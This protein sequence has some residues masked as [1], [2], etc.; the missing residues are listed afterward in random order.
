MD[1]VEF[2]RKFYL[3]KSPLDFKNLQCDISSPY[4]CET[5][6][7]FKQLF[8]I[9]NSDSLEYNENIK[10]N[11]KSK[12]ICDMT[13]NVGIFSIQWGYRCKRDKIDCIEIDADIYNKLCYNIKYC[14]LDNVN[15]INANSYTYL[16]NKI[17]NKKLLHQGILRENESQEFLKVS[18]IQGCEE[19][20]KYDFIY[21]DPCFGGRNY[22]EQIKLDLYFQIPN[23]N[24]DNT[25]KNINIIDVIDELLK[26]KIT[27]KIFLKI[28]TNFNFDYINK[29]N[30]LIYKTYNI[31]SQN[32]KKCVPDYLLLEI[33]NNDTTS[34]SNILSIK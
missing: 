3:Y 7:N 13:A 23:N 17:N 5:P 24:I 14:N 34:D 26:L 11:V 27:K 6:Y 21:I 1:K 19:F 10:F 16:V 8:D 15:P 9:M 25:I 20:L 32:K 29:N 31:M 28:P 22:K 2:P 30:N 18:E 4:S 12:R 33:T